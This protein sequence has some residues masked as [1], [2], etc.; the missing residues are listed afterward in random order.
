MD[1]TNKRAVLLCLLLLVCASFAANAQVG[2]R[3]QNQEKV[4][5]FTDRSI[6]I[7]GEQVSFSATL[8]DADSLN[9]HP[10]S[11]IVYCELITPD[12]SKIS[13]E[14]FLVSLCSVAG[15]LNIPTDLLSGTYFIRAYTKLMRNG[16]P[17]T[18]S[19]NEIRIV[20]P[21]KAE[22]VATNT[23][24]KTE[25]IRKTDV[26]PI[27]GNK[28]LLV[29][30]NRSK[31][32]SRDTVYVSVKKLSGFEPKISNICMSVVPE[33][34]KSSHKAI[35]ATAETEQNKNSYFAENLGLSINGKLNYGTDEIPIKGK[36]VNLSI[37]GE[38]RDFM[39]VRTD[40]SGSFFFALPEYYGSRDLFICS[41]KLPLKDIKI[42]VDN[43]FCTTPF[44][45]PSASFALTEPERDAVFK[46]ALNRQIDLQYINK[47]VV[48]TVTR[49]KEETAFY[50]TPTSIIFLDQYIQ[51]PTLED[52]FNELRSQVKVR[53]Q[54][55]EPYFNV[56]GNSDVSFYEPLVMIDWV[57]VDEPS[58]I[59]AISPQN[60]SRIEIVNQTYI[61]GGQT[62]GG[63]ISIISKKGDFA[64]IDLPSTGIFI[65]YRF[66]TQSWQ[67]EVNN[68]LNSYTPDTRNT[69]LWQPMISLQEDKEMTFTFL[70]PDTPGKY[71]IFLEGVTENGEMVSKT[72]LFEVNR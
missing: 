35:P 29:S 10:S 38:G 5:L 16:G 65:N 13:G 51:L 45:L 56:I 61:K 20:N 8:F 12:G 39:A 43:D 50:G 66:L 67:P 37:M 47:P 42:W 7:V 46:M 21:E 62:Y 31:Y 30:T 2:K 32:P 40:S 36:R 57:A 15:K 18:Y 17:G 14:K 68:Q 25:S 63:I 26:S 58:K 64:G 53:K 59:L 49:K 55:G 70:A 6:Y 48:D 72:S 27:I 3:L 24:Q 9:G 52:Y 1:K 22:L 28:S 60:V 34:A 11:Q 19:Y 33:A 54:K 41:E 71:A 4:I 23:S 69:L 44:Q